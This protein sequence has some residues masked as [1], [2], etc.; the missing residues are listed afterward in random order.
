MK[1]WA[2]VSDFDG[3]ISQKDFYRLVIEKYYKEGDKKYEDWQGGHIKD[4]D[5]LSEVFRNIHQPE[6]MI[7]QDVL[8]L[9]LDPSFVP[10]VQ[11]VQQAG[12]DFFILSAGTDYYIHKILN[13]LEI[14]NVKVFSN[15][16]YFEENNVKMK[17]DPNAWHYS[18][19]YGIDKSLV[20]K[21][22]KE[23]YQTV[24]FAGDSEPDSHPAVF[25]D[26]TFAKD[27]LQTILTSKHVPF[28][29]INHFDDI[30]AYLKNNE[31]I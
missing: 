15:E 27:S 19:R 20:I 23:Q 31:V 11:K 28:E 16:G 30:I 6:E 22:L 18:E 10:L 4:I 25:A 14:E 12:G 21:K 8:S 2:F 5:F 13:H 29:A 7:S 17:I 24:Y 1:N 9:P 26:V 3:T